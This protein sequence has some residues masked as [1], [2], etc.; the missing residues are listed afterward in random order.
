[1]IEEEN[2]KKVEEVIRSASKDDILTMKE[3]ARR[4]GLSRVTTSK[5]IHHLIGQGKVKVIK[6]GKAKVIRW[7]G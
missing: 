2:L 6:V 4:A 7:K 3:I 1:M 5:F